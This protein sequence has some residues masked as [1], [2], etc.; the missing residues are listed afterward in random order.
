MRRHDSCSEYLMAFTSFYK[1]MYAKDR[2]RSHGITVVPQRVP[3]GVFRTC[4]QGLHVSHCDIHEILHILE[5]G[6]A[7]PKRVYEIR[8]ENGKKEYKEI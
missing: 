6:Q 4:S 7:A 1:A 2:L 3:A 5:T 8:F